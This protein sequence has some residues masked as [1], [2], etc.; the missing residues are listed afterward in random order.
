MI[1][2]KPIR[3]VLSVLGSVLCALPVLAAPCAAPPADFAVTAA[4]M[5][6]IAGLDQSRARGLAAALAWENAEERGLV[7]DLFSPGFA[8]PEGLAGAY[9]C[10]TIKLGGLLPL[11]VYGWFKCTIAAED[12]GY[13]IRKTTGSQNFSGRLTASG[14]GFL[15]RGASNYGD[16]APRLYGDKADENQ[17]GCLTAINGAPHHLLLE[18]PSPP[19]ESVHDVVELRPAR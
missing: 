16:E 19:L 11:T 12:G 4:D 2:V 15:Y 1:C 14:D 7:S 17:V 9:Q 5:A 10:R 13:A 3:R 6:R 18:L 8:Q